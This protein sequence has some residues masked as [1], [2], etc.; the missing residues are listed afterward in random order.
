MT[1]K[2][3]LKCQYCDTITN[4]KLSAGTVAGGLAHGFV[5]L[6]DCAES[7]QAWEKEHR[8]RIERLKRAK[9]GKK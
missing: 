8:A 1:Y 4:A 6:C 7:R 9:R 3:H 2:P 5:S